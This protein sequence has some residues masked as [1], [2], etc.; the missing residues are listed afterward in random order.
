MKNHLIK[1]KKVKIE[2][3]GF[4]F[5]LSGKINGK[6]AL[7][8]LDTGASK[9]VFDKKKIKLLNEKNIATKSLRKSKGIGKELME[10][11][12]TTLNKF[13]L[14]KIAFNNFHCLLLDLSHVN[15]AYASL[16]L[17]E[18]DGILGSDLLVKLNAIIR[19]GKQKSELTLS[20]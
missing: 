8:I 11:H 5:L 4:H 3:D 10:S 7:L 15:K 2:N 19:I 12:E 17:P 9:T 13:E 14:G 6:K 1:L 18:I 16:G 20:C